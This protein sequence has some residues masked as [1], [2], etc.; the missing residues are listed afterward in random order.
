MKKD[1]AGNSPAKESEEATEQNT[2]TRDVIGLA[3]IFGIR[4]AGCKNFKPSPSGLMSQ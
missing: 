4:T 1:H 3:L 2:T